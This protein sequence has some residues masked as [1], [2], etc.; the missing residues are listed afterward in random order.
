MSASLLQTWNVDRSADLYALPQWGAGYFDIDPQGRVRALLDEAGK[1]VPVPLMDIVQGLKERGMGLPVLLRFPDFLERRIR[2]LNEHFLGAM[3][4]LGYQ[5]SYR[6]VY[7]IKVN[8]QD[9][10]VE[11]ITRAGQ[12]YHYGLEA[13]SKAELIA[14]LGYMHDPD[15]YIV[16]NGYK[17]AE[18]IDLALHGHKLGLQIVL[19]VEMPEELPLILE[20]AEALGVAEPMIGVRIKLSAVS[21]GHWN[22]SGGDRSVFGLGVTQLV[23]L[24]DRLRDAEKLHC[25]RMLHYHQGSQIPNIRAIRDAA[26]EAIRVYVSLVEEGAP[27]GLLDVGGGLAV[28]YDGSQ[29]NFQASCNYGMREYCLDIIEIFQS[30]LD[31]A[32]LA[33]P[34]LLS[35]SG[36]AVVAH[37]SVLLFNVFEVTQFTPRESPAAL[38]EEDPVMLRNLLGVYRGL[39]IKNLQESFNDAVYYRQ[40]LRDAFAYGQ[41]SLRDRSRGDQIFWGILAGIQRETHKLGRSAP[42]DLLDIGQN[43]VDIYHVNFSVFQSLPDAWAI[44]QL[45]P[46]MPIHRLDQ[47]PT[48]S[49]IMADITCDCDGKMDR[50]IDFHGVKRALPLHPLLP[51]EDYFLGVF[52]VGAYQETLG[53]LHNLL[54]DTH[55]ASIRVD[56]GA[57]H[58]EQQIEGDSIADVLSYVEYDPR[59][60][61]ERFR[62]LAERAVRRS[63]ISVAERREIVRAYEGGLRAYT[64][65]NG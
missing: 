32:G 33:H 10:V 4:E 11:A 37:S 39:N 59:K 55:V 30:V 27:M 40:Q 16:C 42:P 2:A 13:G 56:E 54:G 22:D 8:Q 29:T 50:F 41:V 15:A 25:L 28:D 53:D 14:A 12:A 17:D 62:S 36:R 26:A 38:T 45:F 65:F 6:G 20:R 49:G 52:L 44:E 3:R 60:L 63:Q 1:A 48:A 61:S 64:Y 51:D 9:H 43:L 23:E 35:E 21:A 24:V 31:E 47:E 57:L 34:T 7:P 18:F 58:F 19:V 46:V 5:G